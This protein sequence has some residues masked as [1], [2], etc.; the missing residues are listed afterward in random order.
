MYSDW[1]SLRL[2]EI[3]GERGDCLTTR[4]LFIIFIKPII[5]YK[6]KYGTCTVKPV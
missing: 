4:T 1:I 2:W 5:I 6:R 3:L